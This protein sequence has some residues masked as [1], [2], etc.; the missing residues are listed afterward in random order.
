[1]ILHATRCANASAGFPVFGRLTET[2]SQDKSGVVLR[3]SVDPGP[4]WHDM[5]RGLSPWVSNMGRA[6]GVPGDD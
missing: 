4:N 1:M 2:L 6:V 5:S 3:L